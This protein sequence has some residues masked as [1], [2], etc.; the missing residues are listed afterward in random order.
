MRR[1][2]QP[3]ATSPIGRIGLVVALACVGLAG[4]G[5]TSTRDWIANG[6]KVGPS[7]QTPAVPVAQDWI[8]ATDKR[9]LASPVEGA[10][11]WSTS[12]NDPVLN[13]LVAEAYNQNLTVRQA[14]ARIMQARALRQIAVGSFFPQQQDF[15]AL[16]SHN[17]STGF[18]PD[19]H[20]STWRGSFGLAWEIDFW[21]RYRRAIE[22]ADADLDAAVYDYGDV[23]VTLVADVAATYIDIRTLQTRL[24]LVQ[25]NV[26]N[27]RKTYEIT[28][29]RFKNGESSEVDVQQ[30]KSSLV[31]T[32][33]LVPAVETSLRQSQNQLC[34]LLG[35]PPEEIT[36]LLGAGEIPNVESEIALGIPA[37]SLLQRPDVRRAERNLAAQSALI[38]VAESELYPHITLTGTVG[39]SAQQFKDLFRHG[40]GFGSVGPSLEWNILNYGRIVGNVQF[41]DARFQEL[42]AVYQQSVLTANQE[43]EDAIVQFLKSQE[44]LRLQL[45]AAEA[46]DKTNELIT[47]QYAEGEEIDFNRVFNVQ[48]TK[49]Q[50]EVAAATAKGNV[51][52]GVVSIYR[53]LG[54]GWPSPYLNRPLAVTPEPNAEEI[55]APNANEK[56]P[57]DEVLDNPVPPPMND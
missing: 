15:S 8:D 23:V 33:A 24:E 31:Q 16:Y 48:N 26:E 9:V 29:I 12:F 38:G 7:Y 39:R 13:E 51:A 34:V 21:G 57:I 49:T 5:C 1:A 27:Q 32:E 11:W 36:E 20:F 14:G 44:L 4:I 17:L 3:P 35:M 2:P 47:L 6:F 10:A 54:G 43:A 37:A 45:E 19:R 18:G 53:A 52:Q 25:L 56:L 28:E 40:S 55:E 30:A 46:A 22:S 42:L 50:Q 41:Q